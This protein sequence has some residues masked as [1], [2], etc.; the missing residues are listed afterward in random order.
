MINDGF[1]IDVMYILPILQRIMYNIH[2]I[3][4]SVQS[5][6]YIVPTIIVKCIIHTVAA[7]HYC[8]I[9]YVI[10]CTSYSVCHTVYIIKYTAYNVRHTVYAIQCT[11]YSVRHVVYRIKCT[12]Y[13]VRHVVYRI[14]CTSY[15]VRSRNITPVH[16]TPYSVRRTVYGVQCTLTRGIR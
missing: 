7:I 6:M 4:Y 15:T 1:T 2:Y 5:K 12:S 14:K 9:V 8:H 16:C 10:Q 3:V 11:T 13:N